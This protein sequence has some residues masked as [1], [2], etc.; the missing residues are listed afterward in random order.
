MI[1][2]GV[3]LAAV[4]QGQPMLAMWV[5]FLFAAYSVVAN[6]SIQTI[7]TFL[8]SNR[9]KP[10]WWLYFYLGGILSVT[11]WYSWTHYH[12]DVT[13]GRLASKGFE[14][15]PTSFA[16]LQLV[17]PL[18]LL[19]L[20]RAAM[21]VSTTFLIL[22]C[23]ATRADSIGKV[24]TKSVT[25]YGIA[26]VCSLLLWALLNPVF[27][28]YRDQKPGR[29]WTVAQW[30]TSGLLWSV[31]LM[32]DAANVA[33]YLP[34]KMGA[35]GFLLYLS[36]LMVALALLIYRGGG[37]IQKVVSEK[38]NVSDIRQATVIDFLYS[39]ILYY[40]K[41]VSSIP[42]ST[43]W[44]FIGLLAGRELGVNLQHRSDLE[45]WPRVRKMITRDLAKVT[46]GLVISLLLAIL[47]NPV[48]A[49]ALLGH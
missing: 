48:V 38:E 36:V 32:Q 22:S 6:D 11:C 39:L 3:L 8:V 31:W 24:L 28:R 5:G 43:T 35:P 46:L 15:A 9:D 10:W 13:F 33:I 20:T 44:V 23:F 16:L 37:N 27:A 17:A 2:G 49:Q 18:V 4:V 26:F 41:V 30:I 45:R 12:G 42:M 47:A 25:G 40:F 7:G 21:P 29:G 34:R 14:Q 19:V 1:L